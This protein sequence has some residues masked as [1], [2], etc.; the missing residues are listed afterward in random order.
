MVGK[1]EVRVGVEDTPSFSGECIFHIFHSCLHLLKSSVACGMLVC[2]WDLCLGI[3]GSAICAG[4]AL[5]VAYFAVGE[6]PF[7]IA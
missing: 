4:W 5:S 7:M 6:G 2:G 3:V 1:L